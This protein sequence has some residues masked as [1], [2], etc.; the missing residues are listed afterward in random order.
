MSLYE[1]INKRKKAGTSRSKNKS[2]IS[3]K[4]YAKMKEGFKTGGVVLNKR[5]ED[6]LKRHKKHHTKKEFAL[7]TKLVKEGKT[8]KEA[9]KIMKA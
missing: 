5:Q 4:N 7:L 8:F 9:H 2:T 1:N 6:T 3:D